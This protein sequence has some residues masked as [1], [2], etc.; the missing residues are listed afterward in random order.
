[1]KRTRTWGKY[2]EQRVS[3]NTYTSKGKVSQVAI[4]EGN[5]MIVINRTEIPSLILALIE[6]GDL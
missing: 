2:A 5:S 4:K 6:V 3:I 1:M